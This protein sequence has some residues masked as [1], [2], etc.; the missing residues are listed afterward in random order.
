MERRNPQHQIQPGRIETLK[1]AVPGLRERLVRGATGK[2]S[3]LIGAVRNRIFGKPQPSGHDDTLRDYLLEE[4]L[5]G[6]A[7]DGIT[8]DLTSRDIVYEY[9]EG[10]TTTNITYVPGLAAEHEAHRNAIPPPPLPLP[11]EEQRPV[12]SEQPMPAR[13]PFRRSDTLPAVLY[14]SGD[15]IDARFPE[16]IHPVESFRNQCEVLGI[17]REAGPVIVHD[18]GR[19]AVSPELARAFLSKIVRDIPVHFSAEDQ[20]IPLEHLNECAHMVRGLPLRQYFSELLIADGC[21]ADSYSPYTPA[22]RQGRIIAGYSTMQN[23]R[24]LENQIE[25]I[26]IHNRWP[27]LSMQFSLGMQH[28]L[29]HLAARLYRFILEA[30]PEMIQL[31]FPKGIDVSATAPK[32]SRDDNH[33]YY[34]FEQTLEENLL[35]FQQETT[36]ARGTVFVPEESILRSN[37][38]ALP[39]ADDDG[40]SVD[41]IEVM[42][43]L[44]AREYLSALLGNECELVFHKSIETVDAEQLRPLERFLSEYPAEMLATIGIENICLVGDERISMPPNKREDRIFFW[45]INNSYDENRR[46]LISDVASRGH[47][48]MFTWARTVYGSTAG[49]DM[50]QALHIEVDTQSGLFTP[51]Y[52]ERFRALIPLLD[53]LPPFVHTLVLSEASQRITNNGIPSYSRLDEY[54]IAAGRIP[55]NFERLAAYHRLMEKGVFVLDVGAS[56]EI[57]KKQ[58]SELEALYRECNALQNELSAAKAQP[59]QPPQPPPTE[60]QDL[61]V[62]VDFQSGAR[63]TDV[64][65]IH[66]AIKAAAMSDP[67]I[68]QAMKQRLPSVR[69]QTRNRLATVLFGIAAFAGAVGVTALRSGNSQR[70]VQVEALHIEPATPQ[71]N[72]VPFVATSSVG[73]GEMAEVHEVFEA[74]VDQPELVPVVRCKKPTYPHVRMGKNCQEIWTNGDQ[75]LIIE[76]LES[77]RRA[78]AKYETVQSV[79]HLPFLGTVETDFANKKTLY[80]FLIDTIG[81]NRL[82]AFHVMTEMAKAGVDPH[83]WKPEAGDTFVF[84]ADAH[85]TIIAKQR[86]KVTTLKELLPAGSAGAGTIE[87]RAE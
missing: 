72:G 79:G 15:R 30:E 56:F 31:F 83:T 81:M 35:R 66:S 60:S 44:S 78:F 12:F 43:E 69:R 23:R 38:Y 59:R 54:E 74:P 86:G 75:K 52:Q 77:R 58:L 4:P 10:E 14:E 20:P 13:G 70:D 34:A 73:A 39:L 27:Q 3:Q 53:R 68:S 41:I 28:S 6:V 42:D 55:I 16:I 9:L 48:K 87:L 19:V 1:I 22:K 67:L 24:Q 64:D 47:D 80:E 45:N 5:R 7:P 29:P 21:T 65:R 57:V 32:S 33:F 26:R 36:T 25:C 82:T 76:G 37:A 63:D 18:D 8:T 11:Q 71:G 50:I 51:E 61:P 84:S 46:R 49:Q 62:I 85:G 17:G 2:I 40:F